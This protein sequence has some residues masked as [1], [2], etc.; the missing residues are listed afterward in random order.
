VLVA[1]LQQR[2]NADDQQ[3]CRQKQHHAGKAMQEALPSSIA[4]VV[5]DQGQHNDPKDVG[6]EGYRHDADS[7]RNVAEQR[8]VAN[9][10]QVEQAQSF[11]R[12]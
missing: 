8:V 3:Q 12:K 1:V 5:G 9:D 7:Q 10:V 11:E 4:K 6:R 2:I